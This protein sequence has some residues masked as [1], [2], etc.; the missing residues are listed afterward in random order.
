MPTAPRHQEGGLIVPRP[1]L[2]NATALGFDAVLA[3]YYWLQAIQVVG[4]DRGGAR[5]PAARPRHRVV[6]TLNPW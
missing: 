3:D 4:P 5:R 6:T 2:A 1:E